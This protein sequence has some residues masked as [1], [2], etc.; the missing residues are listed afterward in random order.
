MKSLFSGL[1]IGFV[2]T[3]GL[4]AQV[5]D[6]FPGMNLTWDQGQ[7]SEVSLTLVQVQTFQYKA[8]VDNAAGVVITATCISKT[9]QSK[10][11][12]SCSTPVMS[13]LLVGNHTVIITAAA[14]LPGGTFTAESISAVCNFR[15]LTNAPPTAP[16]NLKFVEFIHSL[17]R[18]MINSVT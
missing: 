17:F 1:I 7:A 14:P 10:A 11:P 16:Y 12:Y 8:R 13:G 2:L 15:F 3:V 6:V 5:Q 18:S 9:P 4:G